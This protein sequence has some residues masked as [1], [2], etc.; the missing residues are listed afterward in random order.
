MLIAMLFHK[1]SSGAG[2]NTGQP[3]SG[4]FHIQSTHCTKMKGFIGTPWCHPQSKARLKWLISWGRKHVKVTVFSAASP[5][6]V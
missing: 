5:A 3:A 1:T 4:N 6:R 2:W